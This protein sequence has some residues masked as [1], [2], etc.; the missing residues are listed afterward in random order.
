L[1][2]GQLAKG[3]LASMSS[4]TLLSFWLRVDPD[5]P[6]PPPLKRRGALYCFTASSI[7]LQ[8]PLPTALPTALANC[9]FANCP[10]A[11]CPFANC[12]LLLPIAQPAEKFNL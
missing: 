12:Q 7:K 4:G 11:N 2:K 3:Q 9:L 10:F 8:L 5:P 1:A 6:P